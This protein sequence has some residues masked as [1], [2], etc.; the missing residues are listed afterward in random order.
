MLSKPR[1]AQE[2]LSLRRFVKVCGEA[3]SVSVRSKL[4]QQKDLSQPLAD[5]AW[6]A[7][8]L[9]RSP[10]LHPGIIDGRPDSDVLIHLSIV[11]T[12]REK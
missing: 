3:L 7:R 12:C 9:G 5:A 6:D 11:K 8:E 10:V 1:R 2:K 4:Q